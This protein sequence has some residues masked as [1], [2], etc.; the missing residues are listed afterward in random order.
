MGVAGW[1]RENVY[2]AIDLMTCLVISWL[3]LGII[4]KEDLGMVLRH[5]ESR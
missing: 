2:D 1:V 3:N 5:L 4:V